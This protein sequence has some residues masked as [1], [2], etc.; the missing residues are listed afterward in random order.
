MPGPALRTDIIDAYVFK[1]NAAAVELLQCRRTQPPLAGSWHPVMGHIEPGERATDT[2]WRELHEEL[3]LARSIACGAWA[4]EQV[5]PF[6]LPDKDAVF[7]SPRFAVEVP[8][9]W[10]PVLNEEHDASRW[11]PIA[12]AESDFVWPGQHASIAE[13]R[14]ILAPNSQLAE[15]LAIT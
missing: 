3:G 1:R 6:F 15:Q 14:L 8:P 2:L 7:L 5:H 13:L 10:Q 9:G 4:L 11:V 12:A